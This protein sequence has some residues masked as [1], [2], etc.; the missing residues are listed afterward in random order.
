MEPNI[1]V[2]IE[3]RDG[4]P[5]KASLEALGEAVRIAARLGGEVTAVAVGPGAR[6]LAPALAGASS[7]LLAED[8]C[9]SGFV[10]EEA[11]AAVTQA[12]RSARAGILLHASTS[13]GREIAGA[14][15][16]DL[17]TCVAADV[18]EVQAG[19]DGLSVKRPVYA[20]K[21]VATARVLRFPAVITLRPNLFSPAEGPPPVRVEAL[22]PAGPAAARIVETIEPEQ[23]KQDLSEADVIVSGGR[24]LKGPENFKLVEDLA[25]ALGGVVGASRAVCDAGWRPH[26]DQVGQTGKTVSPRL[27]VACGISGAIQH[28]AGMSSS[29]CIVAINKDPNAPIFQVADYGLVGD[30]FEVIPALVAELRKG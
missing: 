30:V 26:S 10:L 25:S 22:P 24:G 27:Y 7:L 9:A 17:G 28:L 1:V 19:G 11:A 13:I 5:K 18:I 29:R 8:A 3:G 16:A 21:A 2:F 20:G 15:A 14:T 4:K 12:A 23:A 6:S